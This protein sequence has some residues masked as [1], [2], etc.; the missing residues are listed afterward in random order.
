MEYRLA[1]MVA[2]AMTDSHTV[3]TILDSLL[4]FA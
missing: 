1:W 2:M 4:H 3:L